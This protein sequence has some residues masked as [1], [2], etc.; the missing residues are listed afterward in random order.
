MKQEDKPHYLY[1]VMTSA[2]WAKSQEQGFIV[3]SAIDQAFIHLSMEDQLK[4]VIQKFFQG[5]EVAVLKIDPEKMQ[6]KLIKEKN[7]GGNTDYYH[8][9]EGHIPLNSVVEIL[10]PSS[11]D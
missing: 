5:K 2:D 9:Y 4:H 10:R 6:G 1:K 7:P 8:L 11:E 3:L